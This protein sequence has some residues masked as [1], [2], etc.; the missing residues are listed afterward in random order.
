[1]RFWA[2][3]LICGWIGLLFSAA[4]SGSVTIYNLDI[5]SGAG[6]LEVQLTGGSTPPTTGVQE[7][8]DW[9]AYYNRG[10]SK[11]ETAGFNVGYADGRARG[12]KEGNINGRA[13]GYQ[14]GYDST[15]QGAYDA[16]YG[17]AFNKAW[18][19]GYDNG[20]AHGAP[21]GYLYGYDA[22][23]VELMAWIEKQNSTNSGASSSS[24]ILTSSNW[25]G[26]LSSGI[27]N[28]S[29]SV[30]RISSGV[31]DYV[32]ISNPW[33]GYTPETYEQKGYDTGYADGLL[34]GGTIGYDETYGPTYQLAY[35]PAFDEGL[36]AGVEQGTRMGVT[37]GEAA[38]WDNGFAWGDSDGFNIGYGWGYADGWRAI[39]A[40]SY[41]LNSAAAFAVTIPEPST[42]L[43]ALG[44]CGIFVARRRSTGC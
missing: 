2:Q 9:Q 26:T 40:G 5:W 6:S 28:S 31:L 42:V 7:S 29:F 27:Y 18:S 43:V 17:P 36:K 34:S 16:A 1:M 12:V 23:L 10:Y 24:V 22:A 37:D 14:T 32:R 33:D 35:S 15:Y 8:I 41:D 4:A 21:N 30:I 3:F 13:D 44:L 39:Y 11:G 19:V 38:G 25:N 20:F